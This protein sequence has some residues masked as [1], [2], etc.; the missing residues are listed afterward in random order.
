MENFNNCLAFYE[1]YE[2]TFQ[3]INLEILFKEDKDGFL[4]DFEYVKKALALMKKY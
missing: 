2:K 3:E 4:N 1:D